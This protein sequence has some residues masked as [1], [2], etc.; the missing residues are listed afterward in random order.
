MKH[1]I[2]EILFNVYCI[3]SNILRKLILRII[4]KL[5]GGQ[6]LSS[7][8]RRVLKKYHNVEIG[9][10]SYGG[11]FIPGHIAAYTKIGRYCSFGENVYVLGQNH[12]TETKSTHPYFY[13]PSFGYVERQLNRANQLRVGNDVWIGFNVTI[14]PGVSNIGDGSVIGAGAVVTKDVP[15]YA[16]VAG[17][18]ARI[19][20]YRF[21]EQAIAKLKKNSGGIRILRN[22]REIFQNF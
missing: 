16:I 18:P 4:P 21:S 12:L 15:D 14:A 8:L 10:Y 3:P 9:M 7:V 5:D 17:N 19:I 13:N 20:K 22:S 2:C 11:C 1:L 6:M